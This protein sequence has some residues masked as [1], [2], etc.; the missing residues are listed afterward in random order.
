MWASAVPVVMAP[1]VTL[2]QYEIKLISVYNRTIINSNGGQFVYFVF[3]F[4]YD[5]RTHR[6]KYLLFNAFSEFS[7]AIPRRE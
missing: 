1:N 4:I 2:S 5:F 3:H 7:K 6:K